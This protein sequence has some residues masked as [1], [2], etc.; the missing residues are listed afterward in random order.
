MYFFITVGQHPNRSVNSDVI[1]DRSPDPE[2]VY[3]NANAVAEILR[4]RYRDVKVVDRS[5]MMKN[6]GFYEFVSEYVVQVGVEGSGLINFLLNSRKVMQEGMK[7]VDSTE[8]LGLDSNV[9]FSGVSR[10][11]V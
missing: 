10:K 11:G 1:V 2:T 3:D 8:K 9:W 7:A 6:N 5:K 4:D